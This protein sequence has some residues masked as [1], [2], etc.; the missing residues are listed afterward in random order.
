M[1][2]GREG[3]KGRGPGC[4]DGLTGARTFGGSE[5]PDGSLCGGVRPVVLGGLPRE[6]SHLVARP[7]IPRLALEAGVAGLGGHSRGKTGGPSGH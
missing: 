3:S 1:G 7:A 2:N 6:K 5:L 4:W